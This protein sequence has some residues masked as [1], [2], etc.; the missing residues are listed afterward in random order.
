M[1]KKIGTIDM[2]ILK[3][4]NNRERFP[5]LIWLIL[6]IV[7]GVGLFYLTS[8]LIDY[9]RK[10]FSYKGTIIFRYEDK[11]TDNE[12]TIKEQ[13][14]LV[15]FDDL[16]KI[17]NIDY[18]S[19]EDKITGNRIVIPLSREYVGEAKFQSF[20]GSLSII[21]L[22]ISIGF[23]FAYLYKNIVHIFKDYHWVDSELLKFR[24]GI[25]P[26]GEEDWDN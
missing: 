3:L 14:L 7:C 11:Y 2:Y 1:V 24:K 10:E 22:L 8:Y 5:D 20:L 18:D 15:Q 12:K 4:K 17:R 19:T 16:Q 6:T 26:L 21:A 13:K 25:D 23:T 9:T